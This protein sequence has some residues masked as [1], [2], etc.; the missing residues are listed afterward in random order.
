MMNFKNTDI[1]LERNK[2]DPLDIYFNWLSQCNKSKG[3]KMR[4]KKRFRSHERVWE[5]KKNTVGIESLSPE[6]IGME[7]TLTA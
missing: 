7:W 1:E 6:K 5:E 2:I 4:A 3:V